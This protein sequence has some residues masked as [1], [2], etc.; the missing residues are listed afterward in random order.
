MNRLRTSFA[1]LPGTNQQEPKPHV[2]MGFGLNKTAVFDILCGS[3]SHCF[4]VLDPALCYTDQSALPGDITSLPVL[5]DIKIHSGTRYSTNGVSNIINKR[6]P[7]PEPSIQSFTGRIGSNGEN[8]LATADSNGSNHYW[9]FSSASICFTV[10]STLSPYT[11]RK[12]RNT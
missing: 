3:C 2:L 9:N 12:K 10:C 8:F 6:V 7:L 11:S 1:A 5:R 4:C